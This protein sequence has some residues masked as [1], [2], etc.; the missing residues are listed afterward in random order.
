MIKSRLTLKIF[1]LI[2]LNDIGDTLAQFLMKKGLIQTGINS[3][4]L[5]N[6]AEFISK[7]AGSLILWAGLAV[8]IF[9]FFIWIIVLY[10]ADLSVAMPVG[11]TSYILVPVVAAV[12]LHERVD[13]LRWAGI[14][15]IVL[16]IHFVSQSKSGRRAEKA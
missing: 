7:N 6:M 5:V 2:V 9:N 8:Y 14:F 10:R 16:G 15:L 12:F 1:L 11:S 13:A 3:I 4:T